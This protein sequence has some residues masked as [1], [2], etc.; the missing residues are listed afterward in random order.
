VI[1]LLYFVIASYVINGL[2]CIGLMYD[3]E[4]DQEIEK[5]IQEDFSH[6]MMDPSTLKNLTILIFFIVSPIILPLSFVISLKRV[7]VHEDR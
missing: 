4:F 3:E 7:F 1:Y 2:G 6:L 5:K